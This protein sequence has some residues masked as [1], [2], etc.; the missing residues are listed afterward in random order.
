VGAH[1]DD[2]KAD[3]RFQQVRLGLPSGTEVLA[4]SLPGSTVR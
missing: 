3:P 2:D 1:H 4:K